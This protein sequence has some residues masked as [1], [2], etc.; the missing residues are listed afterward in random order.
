MDAALK[1]KLF[2]NLQAKKKKKKGIGEK[3]KQHK[4]SGGCFQPLGS[5][6]AHAGK[7][8]S[9]EFTIDELPRE[10]L[11]AG[12]GGLGDGG[13]EGTPGCCGRGA[14]ATPGS[15]VQPHLGECAEP[16]PRLLRDRAPEGTAAFE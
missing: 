13:P 15:A 1:A 7:C 12:D 14:A 9:T 16:S 8:C 11:L 2:G 5:L 6:T 10:A 3:N 4:K